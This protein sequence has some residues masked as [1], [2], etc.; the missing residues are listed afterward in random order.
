MSAVAQ[1]FP[2]SGEDAH[3]L[4][5]FVLPIAWREEHIRIRPAGQRTAW[6]WN[7]SLDRPTIEPS[8]RH[9]GVRPDL[10]GWHYFLRDGVVQML[11]DSPS[12]APELCVALPPAT[13]WAMFESQMLFWTVYREPRDHPPGSW[14]LRVW[15]LGESRPTTWCHVAP[16]VEE[17]RRVIPR[18]AIRTNRFTIDDPCIA[19]VWL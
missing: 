1:L 8:V 15:A 13:D 17:L 10:H 11:S 16:S 19:E 2:P 12:G 18:R 9:A 5:R 7:G 14:V 3:S 4:L 6:Q